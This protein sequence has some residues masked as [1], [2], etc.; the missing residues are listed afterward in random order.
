MRRDAQR[1]LDIVEAANAAAGYLQSTSQNDFWAMG[2]AH[3]AILR[4]LTVAGEAAYKVSRE[5]RARHPE[6]PW[7]QIAGFRHRVVHDYFGLDLDA[8]WQFA[9]VELPLLRDQ[10]LAIVAVE[11]PQDAHG[12]QD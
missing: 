5:I 2:L 6:V 10:A 3:D 11:F 1:L 9:T 4:Q 7:G 8:V 12:P